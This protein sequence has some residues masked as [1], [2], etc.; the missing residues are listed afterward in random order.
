MI[1]KTYLLD[2]LCCPSCAAKIEKRIA[3]LAG[4]R[5]VIL[6]FAAQKLS[7]E[8][9]AQS[10]DACENITGSAGR[11]IKDIEPEIEIRDVSAPAP[12][13]AAKTRDSSA[14]K[15]RLRTGALCLS[16]ALFVLGMIPG[17]FAGFS[18]ALFIASYLL[19]GW[20][21]ILK[22]VKN[23]LKGDIFDENFLMAAATAGAFAIGER[24]EA[25]AVMIFYQIGEAFQD[26]AVNRSRK[27]IAALMDLRPD[28]ANLK[29][30]A[31]IERVPP[32]TVR[33]DDYIL[34]R[35]GEKIPLDGTVCEGV[36]ALDVS[37]LTGEALPLDAGPGSGVLSG[38]INKTGLLTI[39]VTKTFTE[40][41]ASKILG[42]VQDAGGRKSPT[43]NF[44]TKFAR[45]YTPAVVF[46]ALALGLIPPLFI[47]EARFSQWIHRALV[48]LVVSCPCALVIS[49]P[50]T[51][52]GGIGGA[53]RQGI[54]VKGG[55]YLAA[56]AKMNVIAFDKTGTLTSCGYGGADGREHLNEALKPGSKEA[57]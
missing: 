48:F 39:K 20:Q 28:Y 26:M 12:P 21:V 4:V 24:A 53:S 55:N 8:I 42:L 19:A 38:S 18:P 29:T 27:S 36:S 31:G 17:I 37:A 34:V 56:L 54:L 2:G 11:I 7:I 45:Y 44:I 32:E 47:P 22:S 35:P 49:I 15:R 9:E 40:S 3:A 50:L 51:F 10:P 43:E 14:A 1:Q 16:A 13:G 23:I 46:L 6:D 25:A 57:I 52:F 30:K 5:Q 41:T 33:L